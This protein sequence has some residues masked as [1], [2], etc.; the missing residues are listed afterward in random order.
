MYTCSVDELKH[1]Y[2]IHILYTMYKDHNVQITGINFILQNKW[3]KS[4]YSSLMMSTV[5]PAQTSKFFSF[6]LEL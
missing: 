5:P 1:M 4:T 2:D 3:T 6:Y